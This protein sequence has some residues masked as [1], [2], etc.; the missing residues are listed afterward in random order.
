MRETIW[1]QPFNAGRV[2]LFQQRLGRGAD[3]WLLPQQGREKKKY[4][5][6]GLLC[7]SAVVREQVPDVA[8]AVELQRQLP[9]WNV[10]AGTVEGGGVFSALA[11]AE[12]EVGIR[13]SAQA[14][15]ARDLLVATGDSSEGC[16]SD[17][18]GCDSCL[19][20]FVNQYFMYDNRSKF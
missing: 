15:G 19:S 7:L 6:A 13:G 5:P 10:P 2:D 8:L 18:G 12:H 16:D 20:L 3:L 1:R 14:R 11:P 4:S 17:N 9:V